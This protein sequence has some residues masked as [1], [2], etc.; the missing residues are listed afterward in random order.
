[1]KFDYRLH[2]WD[3]WP[4]NELAGMDWKTFSD[5][6]F[7]RLCLIAWSGEKVF[8]S[9]GGP[10]RTYIATFTCPGAIDSRAC[11]LGNYVVGCLP[12]RGMLATRK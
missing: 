2:C 11:P 12:C 3:S 9:D 4:G 8:S 1:M 10:C 6:I 5:R 7:L